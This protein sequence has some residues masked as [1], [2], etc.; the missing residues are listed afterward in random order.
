MTDFKLE[1]QR[2]NPSKSRILITAKESQTGAD[3]FSA[4]LAGLLEV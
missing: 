3:I 4:G 2:A 1:K